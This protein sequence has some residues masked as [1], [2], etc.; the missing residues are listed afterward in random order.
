M[1][2]YTP[3]VMFDIVRLGHITELEFMTWA[4]EL[5]APVKGVWIANTGIPPNIPNWYRLEVKFRDGFVSD[6][7]DVKDWQWVI[8]NE[9]DD[10]VAYRIFK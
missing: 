8:D 1:S 10:I 7:S 2:K 9:P 6:Q 3:S 4:E 5:Q